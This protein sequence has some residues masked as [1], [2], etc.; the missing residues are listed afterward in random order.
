MGMGE[1]VVAISSFTKALNQEAADKKDVKIDLL[2]Y[3]GTA[4]YRNKDYGNA[5]LSYNQV[6]ELDKKSQYYYL[7]GVAYLAN[8]QKEEAHADYEQAIILDAKN[9]E[10]YTNIYGSFV[11]NGLENEGSEYLLRAVQNLTEEVTILELGVLYYYL[12]DSQNAIMYLNQA[13]SEGEEKATIYLGKVYE[14]IQ[15]IEH[16]LQMY[17]R[18][19]VQVGEDGAAYNGIAVCK[20]IEGDYDSAIQNIQKGL[21]L[22]D[23]AKQSLLFNEIVA[24]TKK[25]DF[26]TAKVK[27]AEYVIAYPSDENGRKENEFLQT[28]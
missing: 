2:L 19:L 26:E 7:R 6:L 24:Y 11:N 17:T 8:G 13:V 1:Y 3:K 28:R 18:Y 4:E 16:A 15:D 27:A 14:S 12:G 5:I 9:I 21:L 20:I 10:L 23:D 25:L 22:N